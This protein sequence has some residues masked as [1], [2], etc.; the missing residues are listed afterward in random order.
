M[1][2]TEKILA[3]ISIMGILLNLFLVPYGDTL[4]IL[5]MSCLAVL[6][7]Y[8]SF[9]LFN[10]IPLQKVLKRENHKDISKRTKIGTNLIG[11]ILALITIGIL[12]KLQDWPNAS[13]LL[14]IGFCGLILSA[15]ISFI[16]VRQS[17]PKLHYTLLT[18]LAT[19]SIIGF[20]F[21][22][23]PKENLLEFKYRN[24]PEYVEAVKKAWAD[25]SNQDL[26]KKVNEE[27]LKIHK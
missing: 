20:I 5:S 9:A 10:D 22:L 27:S 21:I 11:M 18:R 14:N 3:A 15:I 16:K 24:H 19:F 12:F 7:M 1:K 13:T 23:T 26:W 6:Y 17:N 8:L 4:S 25:P 2:K